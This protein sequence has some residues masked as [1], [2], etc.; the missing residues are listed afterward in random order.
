MDKVLKKEGIMFMNQLDKFA[1]SQCT[2]TLTR[3]CNL[4]C[5]FCYAKK[6]EY[7]ENEMIEYDNLKKIIDF[8][9]E[10]KIKFIVFTGGEPTLYPDFLE[11]LKYIKSKSHNMVPTIATNGILLENINYCKSLIDNGIGYIDISLKGKDEYD[12]KAVAGREC[13]TQQMNAI[14]NLSSLPIDFTCSMVLTWDNIDSFCEAVSQAYDNGAKQFSFTFVIDNE[15]SEEKD[16]EYLEKHNPFELVKLFVSQIDRLN[17]ITS[18]W[19]I[20]YSFPM[21]VYT[22]EQL[23]LLKGRLATP[24]QIHKRNGITFDTKL[25][26]LPCNM[27]LENK[28]EKFGDA[29]SSYKEFSN[30]AQIPHYNSVMNT[31][32]LLPSEDCASCEYFELC[33]GGCP[34]IWKNYSYDAFKKIKQK[35]R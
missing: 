23:A 31:L 19:W 28:C 13:F 24:C 4:R 11:I 5:S 22:K 7:I 8:C 17:S 2:I 26:L 32:N 6:T 10:G 25:N 3:N 34:V 30:P 18:D 12:C 29:F 20:E 1:I 21:C 16:L 27:Y 33:Y 9:D 35:V 15:D 14:R